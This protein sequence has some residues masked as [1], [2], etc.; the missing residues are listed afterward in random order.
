VRGA[1]EQETH[2]QT[3][4][5][6]HT[7]LKDTHA[8]RDKLFESHAHGEALTPQPHGTEETSVAG[9]ANDELIKGV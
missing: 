2:T 6:T 8:P 5:H 7:R 1:Q 4:T 3:H 9:R